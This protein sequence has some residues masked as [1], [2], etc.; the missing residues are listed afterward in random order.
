MRSA[1]AGNATCVGWKRSRR[2]RRRMA[3]SRLHEV[4]KLGQSVWIDSLS[5]EWLK[6]GERKR[7]MEE[8]AVTGVTSNPTIFQK[9]MA[10]G[11]WY[12]D[13]IRKVIAQENDVK[14]IFLQ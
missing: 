2:W 7:M 6:T 5:R 8:E 12:D 3:D 1:R 11:D 9:A 13:Q 14:E 4:A 10:E